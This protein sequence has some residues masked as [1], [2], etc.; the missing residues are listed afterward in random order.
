MSDIGFGFAVALA[1]ALGFGAFGYAMG[2]LSADK[3]WFNDCKYAGQHVHF[4][5]GQPIVFDCK[6]KE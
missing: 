2:G 5:A 4:E 6:A 1:M 3:A